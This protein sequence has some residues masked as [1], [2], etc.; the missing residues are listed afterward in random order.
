[1]AH[2]ACINNHIMWN[3]DGGPEI[4]AYP[5]SFF[6]EFVAAHPG[7]FLLGDEFPE[8]DHSD[9]NNFPRIYDC[10]EWDPSREPDCWLCDECQSL[11]VFFSDKDSRTTQRYDFVK[12]EKLYEPGD[13]SFDDWEDYVAI[14][15]DELEKFDE[16]YPG[17]DP[18]TALETYPFKYRY[19]VSPDQKYI[20][21]FDQNN[22]MVFSYEQVRFL[23]FKHQERA[24]QNQ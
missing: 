10:F 22:N 24:I 11:V 23:E 8:M 19:K 20:C 4:N 14:R 2:C 3:G 13:K 7:V 5:I 21:A 9:L 1:M 18:L 17:L 16:W 6:K 15:N 12:M